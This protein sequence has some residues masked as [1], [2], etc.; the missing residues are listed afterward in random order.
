MR[1]DD[2]RLPGLFVRRA[3]LRHSAVRN[4]QALEMDPGSGL[5][6]P[7]RPRNDASRLHAGSETVQP[8]GTAQDFTLRHSGAAEGGTRNLLFRGTSSLREEADSGFL[9]DETGPARNDEVG[10]DTQRARFAHDPGPTA[11]RLQAGSCSCV[12]RVPVYIP[13]FS[14]A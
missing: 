9:P 4:F 8:F 10:S 14:H 13:A 6:N 1:G 5:M 2:N 11:G 3:A 12:T 7:G